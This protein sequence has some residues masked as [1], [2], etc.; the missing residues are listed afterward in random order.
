MSARDDAL[1]RFIPAPAEAAGELRLGVV[2]GTLAALYD[3]T[4]WVRVD[5]HTPPARARSTIELAEDDVDREFVVAF[6]G[7]DPRRPLILGRVLAS[8]AAPRNVVHARA[9]GER[10]VLS[11]RERIVL[12][13]GAASITLT[14][15]GKVLIHGHYVQSRATGVNSVK[16]G[17][18][19]LN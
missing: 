12:E 8:P 18:V 19:E 5:E 11:A 3:D 16:G 2:V 4:A 9:D 10:L 13:C 6:D 7:G 17:S 14:R 1:A 15:A